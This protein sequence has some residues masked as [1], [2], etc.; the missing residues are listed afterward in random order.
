MERILDVDGKSA[1]PALTSDFETIAHP[2][3]LSSS[4]R[5]LLPT[6]SMDLLEPR[7][8]LRFSLVL[9]GDGVTVSD[10]RG[11]TEDRDASGR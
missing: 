5:S 1:T 7:L 11:R 3:P 4:F 6:S 10:E 9:G 2:L 8:F